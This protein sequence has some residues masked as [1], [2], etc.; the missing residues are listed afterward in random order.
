MSKHA[1]V[2]QE[3]QIQEGFRAVESMLS[4]GGL[5]WVSEGTN[6]VSE[7][8]GWVSTTESTQGSPDAAW[9]GAPGSVC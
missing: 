3:T 4:V 1:E 6:Q 9:L 8:L 2:T 7:R 5:D